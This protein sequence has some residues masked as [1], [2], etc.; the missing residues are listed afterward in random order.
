MDARRGRTG[1]AMDETKGGTMTVYV[2][3]NYVADD[4]GYQLD[5]VYASLD[6]ALAS[7]PDIWR[8]CEDGTWTTRPDPVGRCDAWETITACRVMP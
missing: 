6:G 5:G 1:S 3:C 7:S 2:L 4:G 8:G